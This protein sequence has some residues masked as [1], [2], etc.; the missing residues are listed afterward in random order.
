MALFPS[1]CLYRCVQDKSHLK[2]PSGLQNGK[3]VS[4]EITERLNKRCFSLFK[5]HLNAEAVVSGRIKGCMEVR[6]EGCTVSARLLK[7]W[8]L[9]LCSARSVSPP[10]GW[11]Q[12]TSPLSVCPSVLLF[13]CHVCCCC[14][15]TLTGRCL[16][17]VIKPLFSLF[18][19]TFQHSILAA[20]NRKRI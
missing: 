20:C 3:V 1:E 11:H 9:N 14:L 15:L 16:F 6:H 8:T 7:A 4:R 10:P 13:F 17:T 5:F 12:P 19:V 18:W 2:R